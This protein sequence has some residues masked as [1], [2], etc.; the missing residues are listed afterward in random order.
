LANI[1][2]KEKKILN[3]SFDGTQQRI[4]C[5]HF[6]IT[7]MLFN[8]RILIAFLLTL[9]VFFLISILYKISLHNKRKLLT[10]IVDYR[11]NPIT[12]ISVR[13]KTKEELYE[14]YQTNNQGQVIFHLENNLN[15]TEYIQ[16]SVGEI[17]EKILPIEEEVTI[18]LN[19]INQNTGEMYDDEIFD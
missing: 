6:L 2:L 10:T 3:E 9:I 11:W 5:H 8:R 17:D 4:I 13:F 14:E 16:I 7:M 12:N 19:M 15:N 18:R 1:V